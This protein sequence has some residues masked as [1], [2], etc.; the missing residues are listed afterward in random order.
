MENNH[1]EAIREIISNVSIRRKLASDSFKYFAA[2]YMYE[3]LTYELAPFHEDFMQ[4]AEDINIPLAV[5][6]AFRSSGKSTIF[7][8]WYPIWAA[9][10]RQQK[11]F[12]LII[13]YNQTQARLIMRNIKYEL[14]NN[15]LLKADIGPFEDD[16]TEWS[17]FS[18]VLKHYNAR[19]MVASI[20]QGLRGFKHGHYRPDVV[21]LDDVQDQNSMRSPE[22]R[23]KL[24]DWYT[25]VVSPLS[26]IHKRK[27]VIV[28]TRMDNDDLVSRLIDQIKD[29]KLEG[30]YRIV[31]IIQKGKATWPG[32]YPDKAAIAKEKKQSGGRIAWSSEYLM[33][34]L[35]PE[36]QIIKSEWIS[37]YSEL[38]PIQKL[39]YIVIGVDLATG[40]KIRS[41][42]TAMVPIYVY[43]DGEEGEDVQCYVGLPL[44]NKK[45]LTIMGA[46]ETVFQLY[47]SLPNGHEK[48][49][50]VEDV[51]YQLEALKYM[52]N[53][54]MEVEGT[55]V[56]GQPKDV[57]LSIVSPYLESG[58]VHFP[59]TGARPLI[60]Q[61]TQFPNVPH[62]DLMDAFVYAMLRILEEESKPQPTLTILDLDSGP[63]WTP[64]NTIDDLRNI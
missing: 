53:K 58:R 20:D 23:D 61:L 56:H 16:D 47:Q 38:P 2:I 10:G 64:I 15:E 49:V 44:I 48:I 37:Y 35:S 17:A 27:T 45:G 36:D 21:I 22:G 30:I 5:I 8:N 18:I 33:E 4:I 51:G 28:G 50:V 59:L 43:E 34:I 31:P 24:Y 29:K 62:D 39:K 6:L 25:K 13:T 3:H 1:D 57:R 7:S 42:S 40:E 41:D 26:D 12:I 9:T 63:H 54:P 14:E 55:K 19:I 52:K 46:T 32:K 11:K 60:N